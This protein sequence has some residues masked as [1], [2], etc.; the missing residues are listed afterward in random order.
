MRAFLSV[1][2]AFLF[3]E[4]VKAQKDSYG[5]TRAQREWADYN[6]HYDQRV[7]EIRSKPSKYG[8]TNSSGNGNWEPFDW[9]RYKTRQPTAEEIAQ[10]NKRKAAEAKEKKIKDSIEAVKDA[11][12]KKE[13]DKLKSA[14]TTAQDKTFGFN[15]R[16]AAID[17]LMNYYDIKNSEMK[18]QHGDN[19]PLLSYTSLYYYYGNLYFDQKKFGSAYDNYA[20]SIASSFSINEEQLYMTNNYLYCLIHTTYDYDFAAVQS[21]KI[22]KRNKVKPT[23]FAYTL[24]LNKQLDASIELYKSVL[25]NKEIE[26][27]DSVKTSHLVRMIAME[28]IQNNHSKAL[29]LVN[30]NFDETLK[31]TSKAKKIIEGLL[32]EQIDVAQQKNYTLIPTSLCFDIDLFCLLFPENQQAIALRKNIGV[33]LKNRIKQA[34]IKNLWDWVKPAKQDYSLDGYLK[35]AAYDQSFEAAKERLGQSTHKDIPG[36]YETTLKDINAFIASSMTTH[37]YQPFEVK[38][39]Y[40]ILYYKVYK[41]KYINIDKVK[42]IEVLDNSIYMK[43]DFYDSHNT[44][45]TLHDLFFHA[46]DKNQ[47][48]KKLKKLFETLFKQMKKA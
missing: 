34:D 3:F 44:Y 41:P 6:R 27:D 22:F 48:L 15:T 32:A 31:D 21:A 37:I 28:F 9:S 19:A 33:A 47:D 8:S 43:G 5:M 7:S 25:N 20:K 16:K 45:F 10:E 39:G 17:F 4:N 14:A 1:L 12:W 26:I 35:R 23:E 29:T 38:E 2:I 13:L 46:K 36:N 30:N 40:L 42:S 18:V 11:E 24:F